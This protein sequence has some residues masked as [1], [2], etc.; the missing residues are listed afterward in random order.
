MKITGDNEK[1]YLFL[2]NMGVNEEGKAAWVD[3]ADSNNDGVISKTEL[4]KILEQSGFDF[5]ALDGWNGEK[6]TKSENDIINKFWKNFNTN[7]STSKIKGTR[8]RNS[9]GL[10]KKELDSMN[11]VIEA[12]GMVLSY[13]DTIKTPEI[14]K[15]AN[16]D[17]K[18]R[19]K[20][21]AE[22]L[23]S[24]AK[25]SDEVLNKI[26]AMQPRIEYEENV[27]CLKAIC[28]A[29]AKEKS[30]IGFD[31]ANS[32]DVA[33]IVE[34]KLQEL[35]KNCESGKF[36]TIE[37]IKTAIEE[38]ISDYVN[39]EGVAQK[40]A[41]EGPKEPGLSDYKKQLAE[42]QLKNL[43]DANALIT[44]KIAEL[45]L[46]NVDSA[47]KSQ[48]VAELGSKI[49]S[50][51]KDFIDGLKISSFN[52]QTLK[53]EFV[54]DY[55][56]KAQALLTNDIVQRAQANNDKNIQDAKNSAKQS[57][58]TTKKNDLEEEL[59]VKAYSKTKELITTGING[60]KMDETTAESFR[61][62]NLVPAGKRYIENCLSGIDISKETP[63]SLEQILKNLNI[64]ISSFIDD[65]V[66]GSGYTKA[67]N[68]V[69]NNNKSTYL[70]PSELEGYKNRIIPAIRELFVQTGSLVFN[71]KTFYDVNQLVA[72]IQNFNDGAKLPSLISTLLEKAVKPQTAKEYA[73]A[74]V[75]VSDKTSAIE[76][77][78][79][80]NNIMYQK[81]TLSFRL[82]NDG[83]VEFVTADWNSN[84]AKGSRGGIFN[85][86]A[87]STL[88]SYFN[89][90]KNELHSQ[91]K[92]EIN[93]LGLTE[94]EKKNLFN[95]ALYMT[96][97]DTSV[98][99]SMY[100]E[101]QL[102][103][104]VDSLLKNYQ[105]LLSKI[106]KDDNARK[107][108]TE[109]VSNNILNGRTLAT[110]PRDNHKYEIG[111]YKNMTK[112]MTDYYT[113]D[114]T[115]GAGSDDWVAIDKYTTATYGKGQ[116]I[117]INSDC[118]ED[119]N[120]V[121]ASLDKLCNNYITNY[122][123]V[124]SEQ[125]IVSL[126]NQAE[127]VAIDKLQKTTNLSMAANT[128]I[129]GYSENGD[130]SNADYDTFSG[131]F[132]SVQ[133]ILLEVMFEMERLIAKKVMGM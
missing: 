102:Y 86:T 106:S 46:N 53:T 33:E 44:A 78:S 115:N 30:E 125:D 94:Q 47:T 120:A 45:K 80:I 95:L 76:S 96:L 123:D 34:V 54:N 105:K 10:D 73:Q 6:A 8:I 48:L 50:F 49:T 89:T 60:Y 38:S 3:E 70:T 14:F 55:K 74:N 92:D 57:A 132:Y 13:L 15:N 51:R 129:Y 23:Y 32:N 130:G 127:K 35:L 61:V 18:G 77:Q 116:I 121:N 37:Q 104:V 71:G 81:G 7:S 62:Q 43:V 122:R 69:S 119:N 93:R 66:S 39:D 131:D 83:T 111:Y 28:F 108:V 98:L 40:R 11:L 5:S 52:G 12:E 133:S 27:A 29:A 65:F 124:L 2:Q 99:T 87:N 112:N 100:K 36:P 63:E 79:T 9:A 41:A 114:T 72:A 101:T 103:N 42:N 113:D 91:Y 109:Y 85:K 1:I 22:K 67:Y 90:I 20:E 58:F 82:L 110:D 107:Y 84:S 56:A 88:N 97:S 4:R 64:S 31:F 19:L 118:R 17:V 128:Q 117:H 24:T 25:S 126:F 21:E 68:N 16:W 59:N 26:K 75:T